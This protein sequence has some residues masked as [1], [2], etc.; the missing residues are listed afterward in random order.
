MNKLV[1]PLPP[2][3]NRLRMPVKRGRIVQLIKTN[4][5]RDWG[6]QAHRHWQNWLSQHPRFTPYSPTK[7]E[8]L[9]FE[10]QLFLPNWRCDI[11][12]FNKAIADFL[13]GNKEQPRLFADDHFIALRL[14]LPVEVDAK[15]PRLELNPLPKASAL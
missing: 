7:T 6:E 13:G 12:N 9:E 1:L 14:L 8:Q 4:E 3:D 11:F 5:Y 10:Y 2:T 15:Y